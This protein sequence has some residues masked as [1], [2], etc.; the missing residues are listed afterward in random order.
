MSLSAFCSLTTFPGPDYEDSPS[1]E[2]RKTGRSKVSQHGDQSITESDSGVR[3]IEVHQT[4]LARLFGVKP[5]T[6]HMCLVVSRKRARQELAILLKDWRRYGIRDIQVDK[7]RN[8][9]FARIGSKNCKS[10]KDSLLLPV[11][12]C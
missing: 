1:P 9:V 7:E 4:W 8:V 10:K 6:S 5:A 12:R 3:K 11:T 2:S